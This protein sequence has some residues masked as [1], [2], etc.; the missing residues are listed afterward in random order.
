MTIS[1]GWQTDQVIRINRVDMTLV[2]TTPV[3]VY[4]LDVNALF[5]TLKDLE[6]SVDGIPWTDTQRNA[7][8]VTLS[9]IT[10]ARVLEI[11]SPYT[12][13]FEDA[14]YVVQLI[15]ANSNI[16]EKT[17]PN[18]VS[19]Q[20]NNSAGLIQVPEIQ[21]SAYQNAIT[22]DVINGEAG[23]AYPIG[24]KE[25]PVNNL[26][27]ALFIANLRG[28]DT[29]NVIGNYTFLPTDVVDNF[30]FV[31]QTPSRT[32]LT[33][34]AAAA[35]TNCIFVN[36]SV[37]G[38]LDGGSD[39]IECVVGDLDYID[40]QVLRSLL[41]G[42]I[43]LSGVQADF[44][45]CASGVAGGGPGLTPTIDMG[46]GGTDL[47][48]R[49]YNG[50]LELVND[51]AGADNVS[52][53]MNSGRVVLGPTIQAGNYTLRGVGSLE[54]TAGPGAAITNL[55]ISNAQ[56]ANQVW[57]SQ[58][59]DHQIVGTY[60]EELATKADIAARTSS[61]S[62][63]PASATLI[64]GTQVAGSPANIAVTD[65]V[66]WQ[67][68]ESA[69]TGLAVEFRFNLASA[70]EK[71]GVF[72]TFGRYTGAPQSHY[73]ELWAWNV[74]AASWEFLH[75]RFIDNTNSDIEE[76]H[77]YYERHIDRSSGNLVIIRVIH[78]V[79]NY[80]AGH[81]WFIDSAAATGI[82]ATAITQ[83]DKDDIENQIFGR[84]VEAGYSFEQ[85]IRLL[86]ANSAGTIVQQPDGS[87]VIRGIDD[88]TNRIVGDDS[89]NNGR[90]ITARDGA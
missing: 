42:T 68:R 31:G 32:L 34:T 73:L 54:N 45:D 5:S 36:A 9:G 2:Q 79:T 63:P 33:L 55:L 44:L 84:L 47:I 24:T 90:N 76:A 15:G 6:S 48:V 23:Q 56:I 11:L 8:P 51:L 25:S 58:L 53:D 88:L 21:Y 52:I 37:T 27:D 39:I 20:G 14:Q 13:T 16:I 65:G 57:D 18:Q 60:G 26:D 72:S 77:Q 62:Y 85:I 64:A 35:I 80:S 29:I 82:V 61:T 41:T 49:D 4:Q 67:L 89:A 83:Q 66:Y 28:F 87:Y 38:F 69:T 40:G 70:E 3:E 78:N 86:V 71:A 22:L 59:Y 1:V 43:V 12:I 19:V 81:D 75:D 30:T 17:N 46:G 50:G 10:Y 74:Q 7:S